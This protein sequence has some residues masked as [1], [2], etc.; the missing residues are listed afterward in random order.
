MPLCYELS[1]E[2]EARL[3]ALI[4]ALTS[5]AEE[6]HIP[7]V[8]AAQTSSDGHLGGALINSRVLSERHPLRA[9]GTIHT[10][11]SVLAAASNAAQ[12]EYERVPSAILKLLRD[13]SEVVFQLQ[14]P[15][16]AAWEASN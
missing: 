12:G 13:V 15:A 4:G 9:G 7:L 6:E 16:R 1:P 8:L 3:E 14:A 10:L 2:K 5:F 11:A